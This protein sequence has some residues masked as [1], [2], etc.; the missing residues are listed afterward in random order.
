MYE[1]PRAFLPVRHKLSVK[2]LPSNVEQFPISID[3]FSGKIQTCFQ[4]SSVVLFYAKASGVL[5]KVSTFDQQWNK[6]LC[7]VF[8]ISFLLDKASSNLDFEIKI[9]EIR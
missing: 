5:K 9:V 4:C 1:R 2:V 7:L 3:P 6:S 8:S